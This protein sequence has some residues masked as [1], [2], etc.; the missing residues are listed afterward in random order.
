MENDEVLERLRNETLTEENLNEL[1]AR[2]LGDLFARR[3]ILEKIIESSQ[4]DPRLPRAE[5][6]LA[7]INGIIGERIPAQKVGM[8]T[9]YVKARR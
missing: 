1:R 6:M 8:K 9:I 4:G 3:T 2:S 5:F 7:V